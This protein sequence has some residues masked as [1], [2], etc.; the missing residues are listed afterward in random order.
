M[1]WAIVLKTKGNKFAVCCENLLFKVYEVLCLL[2]ELLIT[3]VKLGS[4]II[5][6]N[7]YF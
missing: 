2:H 6:S 5:R 3:C 7:S 1:G 4:K